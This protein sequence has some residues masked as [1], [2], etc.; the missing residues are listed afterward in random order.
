MAKDLIAWDRYWFPAGTV[1]PDGYVLQPEQNPADSLGVRLA[2]LNDIPCLILLGVPGMGK[3]SEMRRASESALER[4]EQSAFVSLRNLNL[5]SDFTT[6][7]PGVI[8]AH[9]RYNI[10]FDGLDEALSQLIRIEQF[11]A[12]FIR[13]F[14][15]KSGGL[16]RLRLRISCRSAEWPSSLEAELRTIWGDG[17]QLFELGNLR[18]QDVDAAAATLPEGEGAKFAKLIEEY[19]VESLASRPITLNM[20]LNVFDQ[21]RDFPRER[22][23]LYR[24]GLLAAIEETNAYRRK[25]LQ[26]GRLDIRSKLMVAARIA[27]ATVFSNSSLIWLGLQSEVQPNRSVILSD[28]AGGVEPA[29]SSSFPVGET[30][31]YEVLFTSLFFPISDDTFV[32]SHQTFSEFLAAYYLV[33]HGLTPDEIL[34]FLRSSS[35]NRTIA[36]QL[37]EVAAWLASMVPEFFRTLADLEPSVLLRSDVSSAAPSDREK[38][39]RELLVRFDNEELHD[40]DFGFRSRYSRLRHPALA[41]QLAPY[42]S[43]KSKGVVVRRVAIDIAEEANIG[44]ISSILEFVADDSSD[45]L[46]IRAQATAALS[47]IGSEAS[48]GLLKKL[49]LEPNKLD[50]D[51]ELKGWGLRGVWPNFITLP[52]LLRSLTPPKN[53]HFIGA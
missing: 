31:L 44:E 24:R 36:P 27:A 33:E 46:H 52:E 49:A 15:A 25:S 42:I 23:Q 8:D 3:T 14:A 20:L 13:D 38:L 19:G 4:G 45:D 11:I 53:D 47:K 41:S 50:V 1:L 26:T 51:D 6:F 2:Q 12:S 17:V 9:G 18:K 35:A 21:N 30:E 5:S 7:F 22:V 28:L 34:D 29:G 39:V 10:F 43:N 40:F 37:Y 32:W 16:D 48:K